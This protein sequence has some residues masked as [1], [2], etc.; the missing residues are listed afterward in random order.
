MPVVESIL[1]IIHVYY[2][3]VRCTQAFKDEDVCFPI[4]LEPLYELEPA[5]IME[6]LTANITRYENSAKSGDKAQDKLYKDM[7]KAYKVI[8]AMLVFVMYQFHPRHFQEEVFKDLTNN[9]SSQD[10]TK[11]QQS[12][13]AAE[14][15]KNA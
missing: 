15:G 7:S 3:Q 14:S 9:Q 10:S 11:K 12:E 5:E 8:Q 6:C 4:S 13:A 1:Y 2:L